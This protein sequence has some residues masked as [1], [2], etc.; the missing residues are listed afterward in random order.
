MPGHGSDDQP[1]V[2][3]RDVLDNW[4]MLYSRLDDLLEF[5]VRRSDSSIPQQ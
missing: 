5:E 1:S 3:A 2:L 4:L